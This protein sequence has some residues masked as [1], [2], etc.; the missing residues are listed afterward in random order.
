MS[1]SLIKGGPMQPKLINKV[2]IKRNGHVVDWDR[3]QV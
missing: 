2:V 1:L 3:W